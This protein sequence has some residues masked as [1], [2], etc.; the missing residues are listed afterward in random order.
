VPTDARRG[1][2]AELLSDVNFARLVELVRRLVEQRARCDLTA[3]ASPDET[4]RRWDELALQAR[5]KARLRLAEDQNVRR[6]LDELSRTRC[7]NPGDRLIEYRDRAVET[8]RR[9]LEEGAAVD[10]EAL[11]KIRSGACGSDK[12]WGGEGSAKRVRDSIRALQGALGEYAVFTEALGEQ[13]RLAARTLQTLTHLARRAD[14]LCRAAKRSRRIVDFTDLITSVR[15]LLGS[16]EKLR[17]ALGE[18][19]DQLLIDEAQDTD[20]TQIN[21]LLSLLGSG[22]GEGQNSVVPSDGRLFLVGDAKQ[23]IYRFRGVQVE[24]FEELCNRLGETR[25][26]DLDDSFRTHAAGVAFI[27]DLFGKLM[28]KDYSPISSSRSEL[29][30]GASVEILLA[31]G[32]DGKPV[33]IAADAAAAQAAL[34]AQ[35][36]EEM[37]VGRERLVWD[38]NAGN[39]REIS[40]GDV[41]IL[42]SRMT[43]SLPY[44]RQLQR[45]NIPYYVV[46]GTGF[47]RQ[48]EVYDVLNALRAIDNPFDDIAVF[49]VLRSAMFGLDDN[50]LMHVAEIHTPPYLPN[51]NPDRLAGKVD[52]AQLATL[53]FACELLRRLSGQKDAMGIEGLMRRLLSET[54]YEAVLLSRFQGRRM[55]G[56]VRMLLAQGRAAAGE[57]S[58][59]NFLA[60]MNEQILNESR[61]EQAA[62]AGESEDVVR[63]M[64]IHKA[65]GLEFPVV[66]I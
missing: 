58:L 13:D 44:E 27:N 37:L 45:R 32:Q 1:G 36:I 38:R 30:D 64:T 28:G 52:E 53:R 11:G 51:L 14:R 34:T 10:F 3:Y 66:F 42:F 59:A 8:A 12:N 15:D 24:V 18:S 54:G 23:S 7:I 9:I 47:F 62:T 26:I 56:N 39:W 46:A 35:R 17:A 16:S 65:K 61:Y 41:A 57:M 22:G 48:Q 63:L 25:L 43:N 21:L 6:L 55:A 5:Q 33:K 29:P 49:G 50:T 2:A 60:Q 4:L 20:A 31:R 40:P 19:I